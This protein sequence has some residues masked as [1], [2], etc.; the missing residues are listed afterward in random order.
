VHIYAASG[1]YIAK[2]TL[3]INQIGGATSRHF[4]L[5][6]VK[7]VP[8]TVDAGPD[9]IVNEGEVV[10]LVGR[11][12]DVE[13]PDTH[14]S[15]WNFGDNQAPKAGT[16]QE[17]NNPPEAVGTSAVQHAWC[18]NGEYIVTL[19]VRDQNGGMA[20][21]TLK[22]TVLN[23]PPEVD[24][25]P[26][27]YAYPCTVITLMG[28]FIDAGWCDTHAGWWDFGDCTPPQTAIIRETN[29]PPA[30]KGDAIASHVYEQCGTYHAVCTVIDD[31]GGVGE[32]TTVIR[33]V[34]LMNADFERGFRK[35]ELGAVANY[36]EPYTAPPETFPP[37]TSMPAPPTG[38]LPDVSAEIFACEKCCVHGGQRSQR[39]Q[40]Q[41]PFRAGIYQQ[42]GA[43]PGWDYQ[44]STWYTLNEEADGIAR[45]GIDPEG[46]TDPAAPSIV[47][48][49][50]Q[51]RRHWA[52][53]TERVTA[54]GNAITIFLETTGVERGTTADTCFDDVALVP[55][56]PFCPEDQASP[57]EPPREEV[58]VDFTGLEPGT[59]VP[60]V[61]DKSGF[62]FAALDQQPQ[63]I[64]A[65]GVPMGQSKLLLRAG[66][67]TI[68]LPFPSDFVRVRVAQHTGQPIEI[69]AENSAGD[70][71][72]HAQALSTEATLH[73][74]EIAAPGI[75]RL[76]V[77]GGGGE[78]LLFEV[79]ARRL[80]SLR[81]LDAR[82]AKTNSG[83]FQKFVKGLPGGNANPC[84]PGKL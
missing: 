56:Q 52:Q 38:T 3:T 18:D 7:N 73:T 46:G 81:P 84:C 36:W 62:T 63:P 16:I 19:R 1:L 82:E 42:I 45:L 6:D 60:A 5:V 15:S 30:A 64:V 32:D 48:I 50:G 66:R 34:E 69:T 2:H 22:V 9:R 72:G 41:H 51:E 76:L 47:W 54:R 20:T 77:S 67:L 58:C 31:D 28:N 25:G 75:V 12:R 49:A 39:I 59:E 78:A 53:L 14:E 21:D 70:V 13:Y 33:V 79:C 40:L 23:V 27:M 57:E 4:A 71:V 65:W 26:S 35:R 74:L 8:P 43:N 11:F 68:D 83:R 80:W 37:S 29:E 44:V 61:Y 24:A 55:I 17:T 10:T